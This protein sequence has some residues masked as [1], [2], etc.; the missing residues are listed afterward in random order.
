MPLD[1]ICLLLRLDASIGI[2]TRLEQA[3]G[4]AAAFTAETLYEDRPDS[5]AFEVIAAGEPVVVGPEEWLRYPDLR[6]VCPTLRSNIKLPLSLGG[7]PGVWSL[8]SAEPN[9]YTRA[10]LDTLRPLAAAMSRSPFQFDPAPV[11]LAIR[12]MRVLQQVRGPQASRH[13]E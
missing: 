10:D 12:Q 2:V 8:W 6:S 13:R 4:V 11:R 1:R 7:W 5:K 3:A 9:C